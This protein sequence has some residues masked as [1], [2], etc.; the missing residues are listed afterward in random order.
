MAENGNR[1][2][3]IGWSAG[4]AVVLVLAW[5]LG[6]CSSMSHQPSD[7][8]PLVDPLLNPSP[9]STA[10]PPL[11]HVTDPATPGVWTWGPGRYGELGN[12]GSSDSDAPVQA[13]GLPPITAIAG[14]D[15]NSY[16]LAADGTVWAW[17]EAADGALGDGTTTDSSVPVHVRGLDHVTAI[18]GGAGTG[19]AVRADGTV[20]AWGDGYSGALGNGATTDSTTPVPVHGLDH[21]VA[22]AGGSGNGYAL[23]AD[24]T[25][26][27][28]GGGAAGELGNG[29]TA[30]SSVPVQVS[31]LRRITA[32]AVGDHLRNDAY[33]L[34][35]D[36]TVWAWGSDA[37]GELGDHM[38][39]TATPCSCGTTP[40]RVDLPGRAVAISGGYTL[41]YAVLDGGT[42]LG[43][44]S[45]SNGAL[46]TA[47]GTKDTGT[48]VVIEGLDHVTAVAAGSATYALRADRSVMAWGDGERGYLGDGDT[49]DSA[50]PRPV[51][52]LHE[53]RAIADRR[54][55]VG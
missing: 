50:T 13:I 44:G 19:F 4:A 10:P 9:T 41:G 40:V 31:G 46:G 39:D 34:D 15:V 43:W 53:V 11:T 33:A 38:A 2:R 20:W 51:L 37:H 6:A 36:G 49:S 3:A 8:M 24:G 47:G 16:A 32:I 23:R 52:G 14:T 18:G 5:L 54:A 21:A 27:S 30:D 17:G 45:P 7:D 55:L 35:A 22:V 12:G 29:T 25:V 28:W 48:P 26:W 1:K 42:V